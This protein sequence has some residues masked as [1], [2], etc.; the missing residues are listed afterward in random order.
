METAGAKIDQQPHCFSGGKSILLARPHAPIP[1]VLSQQPDVAGLF[2]D[3]IAGRLN[4]YKDWPE[5]TSDEF[6]LRIN[7]DAHVIRGVPPA[8]ERG[9]PAQQDALQ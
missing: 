4:E 3:Y 7:A 5:L 9:N 8:M 6:F 2:E 1:V